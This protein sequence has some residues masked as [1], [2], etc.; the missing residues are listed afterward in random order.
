MEGIAPPLRCVLEVR[1]AMESGKS[2]RQALNTY[3]DHVKDSFSVVVAEWLVRWVQDL[4][5]Q[6]LKEKLKSPYRRIL[7]DVFEQGMKGTP[8]VHRLEELEGELTKAC[9][10]D[11]N[12]HLNRLPITTLFPLMML[13]FPAYLILML[14]PL[15]KEFLKGFSQ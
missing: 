7:L 2:L 15:L 13:Q 12:T 5:R 11:L 6:P 3:T 10:A 14:G 9:E 4:P 1:W 8:I